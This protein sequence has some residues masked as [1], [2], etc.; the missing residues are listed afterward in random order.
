MM[1]IYNII[2]LVISILF[3]IGAIIVAYINRNNPIDLPKYLLIC[4]T[5][6][7]IINLII[8]IVKDH[9]PVLIINIILLIVS[10]IAI[11]IM[12]N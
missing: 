8:G 4:C 6:S 11:F 3:F 12:Y 10:L 5:I 2:I 1:K 7:I 9:K